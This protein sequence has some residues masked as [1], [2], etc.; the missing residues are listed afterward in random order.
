MTAIVNGSSNQEVN[1]EANQVKSKCDE[2][3]NNNCLKQNAADWQ[4]RFSFYKPTAWLI[5]IAQKRVMSAMAGKH[6]WNGL[7]P[8]K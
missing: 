1:Q 2:F 6:K 7:T 5:F 4:E 3:A 8:V